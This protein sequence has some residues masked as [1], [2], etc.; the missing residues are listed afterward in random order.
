MVLRFAIP[1]L[2]LLIGTV[3]IAA[4]DPRLKPGIWEFSRVVISFAERGTQRGS[5]GLPTARQKSTSCDRDG[6]DFLEPRHAYCRFVQKSIAN[7]RVD[8]VEQC[9]KRGATAT[10]RYNGRVSPQSFSITERMTVAD[11]QG[12]IVREMI[13]QLSG[14]WVGQCRT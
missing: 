8:A 14:R 1:L 13:T 4:S 6:E 7:G 5:S 11:Q 10:Y 12:A 2:P 3:A 9:T